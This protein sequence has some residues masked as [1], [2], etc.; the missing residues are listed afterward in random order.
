MYKTIIICLFVFISNQA[1]AGK[2]CF[3]CLK[4]V[5]H[6]QPVTEEIII[7]S[8]PIIQKIEQTIINK[9][10]VINN[11]I[12]PPRLEPLTIAPPPYQPSPLTPRPFSFRPNPLLQQDDP[13]QSPFIAAIKTDARSAVLLNNVVTRKTTTTA[14]TQSTSEVKVT[15]KVAPK[16]RLQND[17]NFSQNPYGY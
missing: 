15:P 7:K 13:Y 17:F 9:T 8:E 1:D 4:P 11:F 2:H 16:Y 12:M 3:V 10:E 6:P 14:S 5:V